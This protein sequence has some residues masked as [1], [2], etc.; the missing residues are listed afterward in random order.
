MKLKSWDYCFVSRDS[1]LT[2]I[3]TRS[4][5]DISTQG[6]YIQFKITMTTDAE[7]ETPVVLDTTITYTG[8][9]AV[10]FFTTKFAL[11][12]DTDTKTGFITAN[13]TE[14]QNTEIKFGVTYK[15]SADWNDYTVVSA[16]K[17][18]ALNDFNNVK[19]GIKFIAYDDNVP[20]VAE[21]A[22][23]TGAD[24]DNLINR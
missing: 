14:P 10:Y 16:N 1:D 5:D 17:L 12:K 21:F 4:L 7:N 15:E 2:S 13:I 18:F 6:E 22:L 3:I 20:E 11:Q 19:V 24:K 23:L 9:F 8:K